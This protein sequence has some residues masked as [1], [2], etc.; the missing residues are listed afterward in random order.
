MRSP[1]FQY[2]STSAEFTACATPARVSRMSKRTSSSSG[3]DDG[4][5]ADL[6]TRGSFQ[7]DNVFRLA[8]GSCLCAD[9][10]YCQCRVW[11]S[12][13]PEQQTKRRRGR[14]GWKPP[15]R[16]ANPP[17]RYHPRTSSQSA[18]RTARSIQRGRLARASPTQCLCTR[19]ALRDRL[20]P[21]PAAPAPGSSP[22]AASCAAAPAAEV[23]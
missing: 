16:R 14:G 3:G 13:L 8:I 12:I 22:R 19:W 7:R 5:I 23:L 18:G 17:P 6:R 10:L 1:T 11:R 15:P 4:A 20:F 21:I 2:K 9:R